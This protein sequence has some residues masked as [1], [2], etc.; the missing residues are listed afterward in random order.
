MYQ[1]FCMFD[2]FVVVFF[3]VKFNYQNY[4]KMTQTRAE[5]EGKDV[6]N[7]KMIPSNASSIASLFPSTSL[8]QAN[9]PSMA[10][11]SDPEQL[12]DTSIPAFFTSIVCLSN[13]IKPFQPVII[14]HINRELRSPGRLGLLGFGMAFG[15]CGA[16]ISSAKDLENGTSMATGRLMIFSTEILIF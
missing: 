14:P 3:E 7:G 12:R 13:A 4:M 11:L 5:K 10:V 15:F 2:V 6:Q 16:V 9:L 8:L 1:L